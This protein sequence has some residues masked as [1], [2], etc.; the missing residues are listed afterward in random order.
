MSEAERSGSGRHPDEGL[1]RR[2]FINRSAASGLGIAL[3][4]SVETIFGAGEADAGGRGKLP[5]Y[6]PL[7]DDSAGILALPAGFSYTVIAEAGVTTLES[8]EPTPG[9]QDGTAS[10]PRRGGNGN[11][12]VNNHEIG[13]TPGANPVPHLDGFGYDP[14]AHGGTTNIEVDRDGNRIAEYVSLAGTHSNCAGGRTPWHTWLTCEETE[15]APTAT[16]GLQQRHGYV[17]EVDPYDQ[18]SNRDPKP[19]KALGRF[20]HEA[21]AV[22]PEEGRLYLTEDASNPNGLLFR[23]TP[24][25]SA[26]PL[27]KGSLKALADDAGKLAAMRA[28]TRKGEFV[29]DLS[30]AVEP[31]TTYRVRW[32][33]VPDRDAA[34]LSVRKQFDYVDRVTGL[35]ISGPGGE[36]TR[37]RKFEGAWWGDCG[38]YI[39]C[40]FARTSDGSA[41]Q[42]DGQV[43]YYSPA[44]R[45]LTLKLRF[46][47][48][49]PDQDSDP[50]GPDGP[51]NI[52]VSPYGGVILAED[53]EGQQHLVGADERGKTFFFARNQLNDEEFTGPNFSRDKRILFA[54]IQTPGH[55]FAIRGPWREE[56]NREGH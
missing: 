35:T 3:I 13:R 48:P 29:P 23:Y 50:D 46:G 54:N 14:G 26:L 56:R 53:G 43:W 40:S 47:Y 16:N 22:D 44:R 1:S 4:G 30:V 34:E 6:G 15:E 25:E 9:S 12:L 20:A 10:F 18:D 24:P 8:G 2:S 27:R 28:Y 49:P 41:D 19:I 33:P 32:A 52:T 31:G 38:T 37:S 51:D 39:V 45:T 11:V 36:V 17:F 42:H 7:I 5:G 55:V 21:V